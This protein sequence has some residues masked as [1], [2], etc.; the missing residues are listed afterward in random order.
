MQNEEGRPGRFS[1]ELHTEETSGYFVISKCPK[2]RDST[3]VSTLRLIIKCLHILSSWLLAVVLQ[4][5]TEGGGG[6][7]NRRKDQTPV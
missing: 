4:V 1:D 6:E 5:S 7:H 2:L 3:I